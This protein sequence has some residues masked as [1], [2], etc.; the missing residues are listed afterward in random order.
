MTAFTAPEF[1]GS[2]FNILPTAYRHLGPHLTL[3][4]CARLEEI[5][6]NC[7]ACPEAVEGARKAAVTFGTDKLA[8]AKIKARP[9]PVDASA[10]AQ[11]PTHV[12]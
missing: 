2:K 11:F 10:G 4:S 3:N 8:I 5:A 1:F 12:R 6:L 9:D 7:V